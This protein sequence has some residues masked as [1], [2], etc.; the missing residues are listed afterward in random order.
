[1]A[2]PYDIF[3]AGD[4]PMFIRL[5]ILAAAILAPATAE[6]L[7]STSVPAPR[8]A[9]TVP[10]NCSSGYFT[11]ESTNFFKCSTGTALD[12]PECAGC[13]LNGKVTGTMAVIT[14]TTRP[15]VVDIKGLPLCPG[16]AGSTISNS[17]VAETPMKVE[18]AKS[19]LRNIGK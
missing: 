11:S 12:K 3:E 19:P 2:Q 1:M 16:A 10:Q 17:C 6:T 14:P 15:D 18:P 5:L 7:N 13:W 4:A 8:E 9:P